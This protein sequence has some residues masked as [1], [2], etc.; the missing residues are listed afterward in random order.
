MQED[1][2]QGDSLVEQIDFS[3]SD[4]GNKA[5]TEYF[6]NVK[7]GR[8]DKNKVDKKR[9]QRIRKMLFI[10]LGAAILVGAMLVAL[11]VTSNSKSRTM[12]ERTK[13]ELPTEV[14]EVQRRTYKVAADH[15]AYYDG[16]VYLKDLIADMQGASMDADLVFESTVFLGRFIYEAG[17]FDTAINFLQKLEA[18]E[19]LTDSN[20]YWLYN[21]FIDIYSAE[22]Y[23]ND[24]DRYI[25]LLD[26]IM[27]E[28]NLENFPD[29]LGG[30]VD[31][32]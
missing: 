3:S 5:T 22:N 16:I 28:N 1:Q 24:A 11:F 23:T 17:A 21:A 12:G 27:N 19:Q 10:F 4:I 18:R 6:S 14:A 26:Q 29:L 32:L 15:G 13:E 25:G 31:E 30:A 8:K 20:R 9:T 2:K 7:G